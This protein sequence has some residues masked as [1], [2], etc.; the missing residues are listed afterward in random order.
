VALAV[1]E[2]GLLSIRN[3]LGGT[4]TALAGGPPPIVHVRLDLAGE[5]LLARITMDAARAL[6]LRQGQRVTALVKSVAFE[7]RSDNFGG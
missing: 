6:D 3:R 7:A 2:P 5:A 4:V 1:G